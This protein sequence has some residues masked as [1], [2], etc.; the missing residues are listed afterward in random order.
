MDV[1]FALLNYIKFMAK[2]NNNN[3]DTNM[4]CFLH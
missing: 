2:L 1:K 3:T 4:I